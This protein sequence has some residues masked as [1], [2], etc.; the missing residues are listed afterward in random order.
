MPLIVFMGRPSP[1]QVRV[2]IV[3]YSFTN[4]ALLVSA[5][6]INEG[7]SILVWSGNPP[8]ADIGW[9]SGDAFNL[10][11]PK[12]LTHESYGSLPPGGS[13]VYNFSIPGNA[14]RVT[15]YCQFETLGLR[16]GS[17]IVFPKVGETCRPKVYSQYCSI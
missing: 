15:V 7:T 17:G 11:T 2:N 4:N 5:V 12:H 14:R 16:V 13:N 3:G 1:A 8:P 10:T 9:D 6:A